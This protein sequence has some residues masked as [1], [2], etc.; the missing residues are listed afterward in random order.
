[1]DAEK[2]TFRPAQ[3]LSEADADIRSI[4]VIPSGF[5]WRLLTVRAAWLTTGRCGTHQDWQSTPM[6]EFAVPR[7]SHS[8]RQ[9]PGWVPKL[10]DDSELVSLLEG[11]VAHDPDASVRAMAATVFA[12]VIAM[13]LPSD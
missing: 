11:I 3:V 8:I 5:G 9:E 1:M 10:R 13:L 6:P 2:P 4:P 7:S 12:D